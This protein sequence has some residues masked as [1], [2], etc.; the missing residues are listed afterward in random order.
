MENL[1]ISV[2][3]TTEKLNALVTGIATVVAAVAEANKATILK[4]MDYTCGDIHGA[5]AVTG[6]TGEVELQDASHLN[7]A[8]FEAE[9]W[10]KKLSVTSDTNVEIDSDEAEELGELLAVKPAATSRKAKIVLGI[11]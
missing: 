10:L 9:A 6:K 4:N 3:T 1:N 8:K 5:C 11:R 2:A 7:N